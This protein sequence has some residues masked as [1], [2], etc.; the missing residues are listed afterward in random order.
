MPGVRSR[1]AGVALA[2]ALMSTA[3]AEPAPITPPSVVAHSAPVYPPAALAAR[4]EADVEVLIT[5][6]VDGRVE[7]ARLAAPQGDPIGAALDAA[8]LDAAA[9]LRFDPARQGDAPIAVEVAYVYRFRSPAPAPEPQ[10]P[11]E[12]PPPRE[13]PPDDRLVVV[14][15]SPA[16]ARR[17]SAEA[18]TVVEAAAARRETSD[19]GDVLA[20]VQGVGVRRSGGLGAAT[21]LSLNGLTD[22]QIRVLVD[23]IPLEHAGY[24]VGLAHLPLD[25]VDRVEIYR[26]V[27]PIRLGADALG[28][29]IDV[30]TERRVDGTGGSAAWQFGS[31][32]THRLSLG[33]HHRFAP[34]GLFV[35]GH[36]FYDVADNDYPV[37]V[38]VVDDRGRP[39][40]AT[41]D[42]FHDAYRARGGGIEVGVTDR[43]W[44]DWLSLRGFVTDHQKE[45]Q[46]NVVMTRPFGEPVAGRRAAGGALRYAWAGEVAEVDVQLGYGHRQSDFVDEGE[47][48]YDWRGERL[49]RRQTPGELDGQPH[50]RTTWEHAAYARLDAGWHPA[51]GHTLRLALAPTYSARTGTERRRLRP[52]DRDPLALDRR[53]LSLVTGL[54]HRLVAWG[55]RVENIVFVKDFRHRARADEL[56]IGGGRVERTADLDRQG[57]GDA[58]R[59]RLTDALTVKVSY[60]R[61]TRL[62]RPDELFGDTVT[63]VANPELAPEVSHNANLGLALDTGDTGLGALRVELHGFARLVDDL[64]VLWGTDQVLVY[65]NVYGARALGVEATGRW[66]APG[67]W[68]ELGGNVTWQDVRNTSSDGAFGAFEG[69][70]IPN[71]PW[72]FANGDLRF[73]ARDLLAG[74][75]VELGGRTRYVRGFYRGWE[76]IGAREGKQTVPAQWIHDLVALAR[77]R[78][79]ALDGSAALELANVGD[80]RAYDHFGVQR[81]G[82][83]LYGKVTVRW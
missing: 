26:G 64:I 55:G 51:P 59:V 70:R 40:P 67:E 15:A 82:R 75:D 4:R 53:V 81:P 44:A 19:L 79:G 72:L 33:A 65:Q 24:G 10:R 54:E 80:A 29:A 21:R 61:A 14:A 69:D 63:I 66:R 31:F 42:R 22:D 77:L 11:P 49:L 45:I 1:W 27:V 47:W 25:L 35:R 73:T 78:V 83:A 30:I 13:P 43:R 60:E 23:G 76:S 50:D 38:E 6:G 58:L 62:P 28:G 39:E 9:G 74:L 5:V 8:A 12:A 41:V 71:R 32:G 37:D 20:R 46:H 52:D 56:E 18:V 57:F 17:R 3:A 68:V 34:R 2:T 16:T 7:A 36:A 48:L